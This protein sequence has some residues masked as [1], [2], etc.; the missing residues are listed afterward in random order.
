MLASDRL[1]LARGG[2]QDLLNDSGHLRGIGAGR[3][4]PCQRGNG[5]QGIVFCSS[6]RLTVSVDVRVRQ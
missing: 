2:L 3:Q 5:L 4:H 6:H 1:V